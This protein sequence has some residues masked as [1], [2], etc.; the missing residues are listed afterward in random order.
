MTGAVAVGVV[1]VVVVAA[2]LDFAALAVA[3]AR[4]GVA[5]QPCH[6]AAGA[7]AV[8]VVARH[9]QHALAVGFAACCCGVAPFL[10]LGGCWA[11]IAR[12]SRHSRTLSHSVT[13]RNRRY[14][15]HNRRLSLNLLSISGHHQPGAIHDGSAN[16]SMQAARRNTSAR[17]VSGRAVVLFSTQRNCA[18]SA[19]G[20]LRLRTNAHPHTM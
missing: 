3:A 10:T 19:A 13:L 1:V 14:N 2:T 5:A 15:R 17:E 4:A 16:S 18:R 20:T 11:F 12:A 7:G 9:Q 6:A 8:V